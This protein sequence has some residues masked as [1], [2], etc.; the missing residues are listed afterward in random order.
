MDHKTQST[1]GNVFLLLKK[2]RIRPIHIII[3]IALSAVAALLEGAG[4]G[5][6]IP[7]LDGFLHK[8]FGFITTTP[9]IGRWVA[10]LPPSILQND[11]LIFAVLM[12]GFLLL[13]V[14]KSVMKF[15]SVVSMAY[16]SERAIHHHRKMLFSRYLSFGKLF[17]DTTNIGHHTLVLQ[18]FSRHA[19][20]PVANLDKFINSFMSLLMYL[21][22]ILLISWKLTL[23]SLPLFIALHYVIRTMIIRIKHRSYDIMERGS[24]LSK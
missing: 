17:F 18:E 13:Y 14:L 20:F 19:L 15:L 1:I 24:D 21:I 16:L 23:V 12:G 7:I 11:R 4:I 6:L 9:Y 3:P 5:L 10:Q 8:S 2:I 22:V